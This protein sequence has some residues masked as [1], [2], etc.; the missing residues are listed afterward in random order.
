M[1][2]VR[3]TLNGKSS[4]AVMHHYDAFIR[5]QFYKVEKYS[6][7]ILNDFTE[8]RE[9]VTLNIMCVLHHSVFG[10]LDPALFSRLFELNNRHCGVTLFE[11][12]LWQPEV[13]IDRYV[14]HSPKSASAKAQAK[15]I[16]DAGRLRHEYLRSRFNEAKVQEMTQALCTRG[17]V[18][19]MNMRN[20]SLGSFSSDLNADAL[21]HRCTLIMDVSEIC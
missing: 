14:I 7:V 15:Y 1:Q 8:A 10:K 20:E 9:V 16:A 6:H 21:T 2:N 5:T 13:F 4:N 11:H 3:M 18:W 17:I 19:M 12:F